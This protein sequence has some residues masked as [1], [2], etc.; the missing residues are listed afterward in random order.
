MT[1]E[2]CHGIHP[3]AYRQGRRQTA[4]SPSV[5]RHVGK[6]ATRSL[7][8]HVTGQTAFLA[9]PPSLPPWHGRART[10]ESGAR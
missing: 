8:K 6:H 3:I 2:T 4:Q 10:E 1:E 7:I 5:C 9:L